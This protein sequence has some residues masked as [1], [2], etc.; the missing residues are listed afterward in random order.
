[1]ETNS[2]TFPYEVRSPDGHLI[3]SL[4]AFQAGACINNIKGKWRSY[5]TTKMEKPISAYELTEDM[6]ITRSDIGLKL[7]LWQGYVIYKAE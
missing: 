3:A 4:S 5:K 6:T 7:Y 1:M 2:I